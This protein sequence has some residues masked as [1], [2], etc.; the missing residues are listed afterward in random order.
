MKYGRKYFKTDTYVVVE[1]KDW[2]SDAHPARDNLV[3]IFSMSTCLSTALIVNWKS[4]NLPSELLEIRFGQG[5]DNGSPI[6]FGKRKLTI[7]NHIKNL[8]NELCPFRVTIE[9]GEISRVW[10]NVAP[11]VLKFRHYSKYLLWM[12]CWIILKV[13]PARLADVKLA[14]FDRDDG[15]HSRLRDSLLVFFI[16]GYVITCLWSNLRTDNA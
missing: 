14:C 12:R 4:K 9:V 11:V 15:K 13:Q 6:L 8:R 16:F 7:F 1:D 2:V 5:I 3:K 10:H